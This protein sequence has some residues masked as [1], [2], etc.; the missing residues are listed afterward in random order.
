MKE[1]HID[2]D[3]QEYKL[4][5][6][7]WHHTNQIDDVKLLGWFVWMVPDRWSRCFHHSVSGSDILTNARAHTCLPADTHYCTYEM[8]MCSTKLIVE[9]WK[10]GNQTAKP[11]SLDANI[12]WV[13]NLTKF[14]RNQE[15]QKL[16]QK[17]WPDAA[18][19]KSNL[20][21][22]ACYV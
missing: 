5:V 15:T 10:K 22:I 18:R 21:R 9:K 12:N 16:W 11:N 17:Q 14:S 8:L 7:L 4:S 19:R 3:V 1:L 2:T 20:D 6:T 13:Q